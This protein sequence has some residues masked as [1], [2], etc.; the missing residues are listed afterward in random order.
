[1]PGVHDGGIVWMPKGTST[2]IESQ[3]RKY[4]QQLSTRKYQQQLS[5]IINS[6]SHTSMG[7]VG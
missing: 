3:T 5:H 1:M 6:K 7:L 2:M 4:Q